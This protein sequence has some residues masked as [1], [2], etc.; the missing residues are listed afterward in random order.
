MVENA[1]IGREYRSGFTSRLSFDA[2]D[3]GWPIV[4]QGDVYKGN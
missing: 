2:R 3:G 4:S 1:E